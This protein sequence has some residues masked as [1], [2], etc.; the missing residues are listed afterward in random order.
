MSGNEKS[1]QQSN[2]YTTQQITV[3]IK[4]L[5]DH[6]KSLLPLKN[7]VDNVIG[8][9][10]NMTYEQIKNIHAEECAI[11]CYKL[12]QYA[13]YLQ[14][15]IN[16]YK[17]LRRWAENNLNLMMGKYGNN[18][19]TQYTK[20][21]EKRSALIVDNDHAK[22]LYDVWLKYGSLEEELSEI[23]NRVRYISQTIQEVKNV[24]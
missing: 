11:L 12:A 18:Y 22:S 5:D 7:P 1:N 24:R 20:F 4:D 8:E 10:L 6:I 21:E 9:A 19:G 17:N 3:F 2:D 16:R 15:T 23:A 14:M 13:T